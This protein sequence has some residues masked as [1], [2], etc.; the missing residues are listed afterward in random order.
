[1]DDIFDRYDW[2][3]PVCGWPTHRLHR[4][5]TRT[6]ADRPWAHLRVVLQLCVR[7]F[8]CANGCCTRRMFT[9]RLPQLVRPWARRTQRLAHQL[10]A[11]ARA[12]GGTA[13]ALV[14]PTLGMAVSRQTLL[15]LLRQPPL[16]ALP[17]PTVLGVDDCALR[18]RQT[19]GTVLIDLERHQPVARL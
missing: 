14:S 16:P 3:C 6:V 19:Y 1:L 2:H 7:Q 12:L 11:L 15:R 17:T 8:F 5:S 4:T 10:T 18:K 13:G 9:E